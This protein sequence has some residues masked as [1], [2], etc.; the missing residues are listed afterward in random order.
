ME[1]MQII[2]TDFSYNEY[3]LEEEDTIFSNASY[4]HNGACICE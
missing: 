3:V 1:K 2:K 4:P